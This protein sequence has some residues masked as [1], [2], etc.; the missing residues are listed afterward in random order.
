MSLLKPESL[1]ER[2]IHLLQNGSLSTA[3]LLAQLGGE[4]KK[5]SKQGFYKALRQL[6][7]DDVVVVTKGA[8]SLNTTWI[9]QVSDLLSRASAAYSTG[10]S[11][12][13]LSLADKE[14]VS[15]HFGTLQ[16]LDNYWGHLQDIVVKATPASEP[17]F[18]YDPHYWFYL[19][20]PEIEKAHIALA[21]SLGKQFL[22]T[23]AGTTPL[24][25]VVLLDFN[26]EMRQYHM[27]RVLEKPGYYVVIVGDYVF[28]ASFE[29]AV[30]RHIEH[31]Y[32]QHTAP[33]PEALREIEQIPHLKTRTKLKVSRNHTRAQTL[34][35][36]LS[37]NFIIKR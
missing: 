23:V 27:E 14:S 35:R 33:T 24:D 37:K 16:Q 10:T 22:M 15:Y 18:T 13:I 21:N 36:K 30:E 32:T 31:I 4:G 6:K 25:K 28:E 26:N 9:Q 1:D 19:A 3:N 17:L 12:G 20:R 8:A 34:K 11:S 5:L 29:E 2:I 7:A